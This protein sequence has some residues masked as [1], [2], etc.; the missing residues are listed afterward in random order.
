M[1][2]DV[3]SPE[4]ETLWVAQQLQ[5][6]SAA[7]NVAL[8]FRIAEEVDS[9][10]LSKAWELLLARHE[11]WR[12]S[13]RLD[14]AGYLGLR[15]DGPGTPSASGPW[16]HSRRRKT[17]ADS[18]PTSSASRFGWRRPVVPAVRSCCGTR[19]AATASSSSSRTTSS[20]TS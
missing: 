10:I 7:Y 3:V 2:S 14:S 1:T 19:T 18:L 11:Q 15:H 9:G 6:D 20:P 4:Q 8:C 5:P 12:A 16:H 17:F 13:F